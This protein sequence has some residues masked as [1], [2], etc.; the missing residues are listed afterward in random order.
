MNRSLAWTGLALAATL[1]G[2][3]DAATS[4]TSLAPSPGP[5]ARASSNMRLR[6][7]LPPSQLAAG[8]TS[9]AGNWGY[10]APDGRRLALT[11]LN[12]GLSVADVTDPGSPRV[13]GH[14][15]A[16]SSSWREVK[17]YRTYAYVTTEARIGLDIVDLRDPASPRRVQTLNRTFASAHTI[18]ID[19]GR[20]LAFVNGTR[21][22]SGASTGMRVLDLAANPEDPPDIGE[23]TTSYV[24]DS[25]TFGNTLFASAINDGALVLVDVRDPRRPTEI[26]R[27]QTGGRF[28]HNAWVTGDGRYVFTTDERSGRPVEGWDIGDPFAPRK[29]S[30]YIAA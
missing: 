18:W 22:A 13:V 8:A 26:T 10:T 17:T 4:P 27:F 23:Y 25:F 24:H 20:G 30:E 19:E 9:A 21:S 29:V 11:G 7:Q 12:N 15:A 16:A 28:T 1:A 3:G 6:A 5:A 2:C 14:F